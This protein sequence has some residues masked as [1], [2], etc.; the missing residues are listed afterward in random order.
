[1]ECPRSARRIH[2]AQPHVHDKLIHYRARSSLAYTYT[3]ARRLDTVPAGKPINI[4]LKRVR[5]CAPRRSARCACARGSFSF[6]PSQSAF[7]RAIYYRNRTRQFMVRLKIKRSA[8]AALRS[9]DG[10]AG[11]SSE[12]NVGV[13][14][15]QDAGFRTW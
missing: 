3:T 9:S 1:M 15:F 6:P 12:A 10:L 4:K 13:R 8:A 14:C 2:Q 7:R 11:G 5:A